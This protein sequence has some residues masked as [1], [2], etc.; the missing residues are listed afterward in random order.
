MSQHDGNPPLA[1]LR[2]RE[3]RATVASASSSVELS[4][5]LCTGEGEEEEEREGAALPRDEDAVVL[6]LNMRVRTSD[7]RCIRL[8]CRERG[9]CSPRAAWKRYDVVSVKWTPSESKSPPVAVSKAPI[10]LH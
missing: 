10:F 7:M 5:A 4:P 3:W 1:N 9:C 8:A 6:E 2:L